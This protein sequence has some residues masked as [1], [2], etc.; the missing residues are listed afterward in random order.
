MN[1]LAIEEDTYEYK[2]TAV[3][4]VYN[5]EPYLE[6]CLNSLVN[7]SLKG[8]EILL[9]ND[10]STDDSLSICRRFERDYDNVK[11]IDKDINEGLAT[12]ANLG[13]KLAKGEYVILVDND[14][15]IPE[16]AYEK[17]YNKAK[18]TNADI[19]IGK[20]NFIMGKHQQE[21]DSQDKIAWEEE[22]VI[23]DI[24]EYPILF[25]D[26][27]Y[28][29]KIF[30]REFLL[31]HDIKLPTG[32][33]YADR[34][35]S[36]TAYIHAKKIAI[37]TDCVYLWRRRKN[38]LSMKRENVSNYI[39]R[40][41][42]YDLGLN[43]IIK[44]YPKYLKILLRRIILPITGILNNKE[45]EDV[46][47]DRT[48][49]LLKNNNISNIY[50]NNTNDIYNI[51]TYLILNQNR[52]EL[53]KL[54]QLKL[55]N[56]DEIF[57]ENGKSYWKLPQFRDNNSNI[58]DELFE[59]HL[60]QRQ[61]INIEEI[62]T[63]KTSIIFNKIKIPKH[64]PLEEGSIVLKG[65]TNPYHCFEED[66]LYFKL[67]KLENTD[68]NLYKVE[69]PINK[70]N[71][72]GLYNVFLKTKHK[73]KIPNEVRLKIDRINKINN[74]NKNLQIIS[75]K[76]NYLTI[77]TQELNNK[78]ELEYDEDKI[79]IKLSDENNLKLYILNNKTNEK[80]QLKLNEDKTYYELE[81]KFFLDRKSDYTFYLTTFNEKGLLKKDIQ[82]KEKYI[83]NFRNASLKNREGINI[84]IYK[85][86]YIKL[87]SK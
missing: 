53:K 48:Y 81:W 67:E 37:I 86:K 41:D 17:L 25:H 47:F 19:S 18:E 71:Y 34:Q 63:T 24:N 64:F 5:G 42:S 35:F 2:L 31:K 36:H 57:N 1:N 62:V 70:L 82:L 66:I 78:F 59:I 28:W 54:I 32:M 7:Q 11:V 20:A 23:T 27:F 10:V 6:E 51:Y 50:D 79:K 15:I 49:K 38:S 3:V 30:R 44:C 75:N 8:L 9:I 12:N 21:M 14:D 87:K 33:I 69:I 16:Y 52:E 4:L 13:I 73:D 85:T 84:E 43:E 68:E 29:N 65:L 45:F 76:N 72:F 58:P 26:A 56:E 80:V 40:L 77:T 39:N 61:F 22:K 60:L 46:V 55:Q 83:K 74:K